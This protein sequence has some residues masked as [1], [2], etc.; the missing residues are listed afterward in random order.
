MRTHAMLYLD[1]DQLKVLNDTAGHEAGDAAI[2]F[3]ST[4]VEQ[5]AAIQCHPCPNGGDEFAVLLRDCNEVAAQKIVKAIIKG[6]SAN[7][8]SGV[9]LP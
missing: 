6:L 3:A 1:L 9:I 7:A 2:K 5:G 8:F 4:I